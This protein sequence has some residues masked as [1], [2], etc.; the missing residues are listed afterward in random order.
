MCHQGQNNLD[1]GVPGAPEWSLAPLSM[2]WQGLDRY[3]IARSMLNPANNGN[4]TL[5]QVHHHLVDHALVLWAWKPGVHA[6]GSPREPVPVPLKE[7]RA[8]VDRWFEK[9]A[10]IPGDP[11]REAKP[12]QEEG[13]TKE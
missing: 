11:P 4:R 6:D 13:G 8:A 7:Y 10:Q 5:E 2:A 12:A 1:S 9:G 3:E